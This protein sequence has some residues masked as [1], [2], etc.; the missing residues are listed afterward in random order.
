MRLARKWSATFATEQEALVGDPANG[1]SVFHAIFPSAWLPRWQVECLRMPASGSGEWVCLLEA[2][3]RGC[4]DCVGDLRNPAG[5]HTHLGWISKVL[6]R[7]LDFNKQFVILFL[8]LLDTTVYSVEF[9]LMVVAVDSDTHEEISLLCVQTF[10]YSPQNFIGGM[11]FLLPQA[12]V[13]KTNLFFIF[14]H[15]KITFF[16]AIL[17]VPGLNWQ[18]CKWELPALGLCKLSFTLL[19]NRLLLWGYAC[20]TGFPQRVCLSQRSV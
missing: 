19:T 2:N 18:S 8:L 12:I 1:G 15:F 9:L 7:L 20:V 3:S 13:R 10:C 16:W 6:C 11:F 5:S 17:K 14:W 4:W